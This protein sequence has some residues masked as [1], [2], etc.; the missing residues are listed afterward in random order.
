MGRCRGR[1]E[2][3]WVL[4]VGPTVRGGL[5][6]R[7]GWRGRWPQPCRPLGFT[8]WCQDPPRAATGQR[9]PC[10]R[11]CRWAREETLWRQQGPPEQGEMAGIFLAARSPHC[12]PL[13]RGGT[14]RNRNALVDQPGIAQR[15]ALQRA[16]PRKTDSLPTRKALGA[17][18]GQAL[19]L[20]RHTYP[21]P[22]SSQSPPASWP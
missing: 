4:D 20:R 7:T 19:T 22:L 9:P 14:G 8:A 3:G 18:V 12:P 1:R 17:A 5:R 10:C 15:A 2:G 13:G 6:G 21:R 11:P 16:L